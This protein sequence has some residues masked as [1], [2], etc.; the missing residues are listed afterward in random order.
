[1]VL[2]SYTHI[3]AQYLD[4]SALIP[5]TGIVVPKRGIIPCGISTVW[6]YK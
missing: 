5:L 6:K 4:Q 2:L 1:M 3:I